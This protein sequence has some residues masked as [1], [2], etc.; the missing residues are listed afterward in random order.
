ME[1][2][3]MDYFCDQ[4]Q[5]KDVGRRMQVGQEFLEYLNDPDVS[6]DIEQDQQRLDKV[7]DDLTGWV[8]SSNYKKQPRILG[9]L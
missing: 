8:N 7:I 1:L 5:Q 4:V 6:S 3:R 2:G 9:N